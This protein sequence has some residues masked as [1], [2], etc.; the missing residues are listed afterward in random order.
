MTKHPTRICLIAAAIDLLYV[1]LLVILKSRDAMSL[2]AGLLEGF[3]ALWYICLMIKE[4]VNKR[5]VR[6]NSSPQFS[7]YRN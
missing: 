5:V 6:T 1:S 7:G 3:A 4:K 2:M